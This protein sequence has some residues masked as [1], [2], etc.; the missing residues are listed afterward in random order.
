[1]KYI[2]KEI[3]GQIKPV[4]EYNLVAICGQYRNTYRSGKTGYMVYRAVFQDETARYFHRSGYDHIYANFHIKNVPNFVYLGPNIDK[5]ILFDEVK[6]KSLLL[7]DEANNYLSNRS[8]K[9]NTATEI[10]EFLDQAGKKEDDVL[11]SIPDYKWLD[12][13]AKSTFTEFIEAQGR[14]LPGADL[15]RYQNFDFVPDR[16]KI[17]TYSRNIILA[18][19]SKIYPYYDTQEVIKAKQKPKPPRENTALNKAL[20]LLARAL[21]QPQK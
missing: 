3:A 10:L 15:F 2:L 20:D 6:N 1:M 7:I 19:L 12:I 16:P 17:R 11:I 21:P 13:R 8:G 5:D 18:D 9:R 14:Y 4:R